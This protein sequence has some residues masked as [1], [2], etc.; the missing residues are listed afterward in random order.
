MISR[1]DKD[2]LLEVLQ[3]NR[4]AHRTIFEEALEGYRT[5]VLEYLEKRIEEVRKG[6]KI[7]HY[8]CLD[9]PEDHTSDYDRIIKMVEMSTESSIELDQNSFASYVMD[10]WNWKHQFLTSNST[11]STTAAARLAD[12]YV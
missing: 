5:K 1:V 7:D 9:Q 10:D 12:Q 11:Y 4:D 8:I 6:K 3:K 2:Q